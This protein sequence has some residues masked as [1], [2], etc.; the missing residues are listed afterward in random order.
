MSQ[1]VQP[2]ALRSAVRETGRE[3]EVVASS[4][5]AD[6]EQAGTFAALTLDLGETDL[7]RLYC[8]FERCRSL[9]EWPRPAT[10]PSAGEWTRIAMTRSSRPI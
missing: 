8:G 4:R 7:R 2:R 1:L 5:K 10:G 3:D 6:V 9:A